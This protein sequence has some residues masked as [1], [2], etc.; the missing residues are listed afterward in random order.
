MRQA[1]FSQTLCF[2]MFLISM[3]SYFANKIQASASTPHSTNSFCLSHHAQCMRKA[4]ASYAQVKPRL[5]DIDRGETESER[6][7][8]ERERGRKLHRQRENERE[9]DSV[10]SKEKKRKHI[11]QKERR[12]RVR[13]RGKIKR[14][15]EERRYIHSKHRR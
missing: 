11:T 1:Y 8:Y 9:G 14:P 4:C 5:V 15:Q 10:R 3:M 7:K 12:K 6:E 13:S 2:A